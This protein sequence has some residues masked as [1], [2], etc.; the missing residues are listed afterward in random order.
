[1]LPLILASSSPYR[2][3]LLDKLG[4]A[5]H[6][7]SPAVDET[8]L[9]GE[10]PEELVVRLAQAKARALAKT[11]PAHLIVGSDQVSSQQGQI[12]GKPGH[13]EA[14]H[15]QLRAASGN[16]L[17][18]YTGLCLFNSVSGR[19]QSL[20]ETYEVSFRE[21]SD[22]QILNYLQREKPFDCA[23]SFKCEGLGISLFRRMSGRDPNTLVGLPLMALIDMLINEGID[24]LGQPG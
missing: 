5:Y 2:R 12:L 1:M 18:F 9:P 14:A 6:W 11:Y 4:L 17:T 22:T 20:C 23:G 8:P 21:L 24:P 16:S 19:C 3:Q 7:A 10:K 13:L 15:R